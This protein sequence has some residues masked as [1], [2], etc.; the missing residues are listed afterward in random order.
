MCKEL[1]LQNFDPI[2][3]SVLA[4]LQNAQQRSK[5]VVYVKSAQTGIRW[6]ELVHRER[7]KHIHFVNRNA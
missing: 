7:M 6:L 5:A 3:K 2:Q 4:M 1:I